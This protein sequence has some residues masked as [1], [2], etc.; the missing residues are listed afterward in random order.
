MN[1][2]NGDYT[3]FRNVR[4]RGNVGDAG[5]DPGALRF[6]AT[7][8]FEGTL[9]MDATYSDQNFSYTLP[10]KSGKFGLTGTFAVDLPVVAASGYT[11]T[12][13]TIAGL[14]A[15][16]GIVVV[17]QNFIPTAAISARGVAMVAQAIPTANTLT[18]LF[19]NPFAT[20]TLALTQGVVAYTVVR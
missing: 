18:L 1:L 11:S 12:A 6:V 8:A 20:A 13:V 3:N 4:V 5:G 17:P 15:E 14:R 10:A 7:S 16:D 2:G 9:A 19:V